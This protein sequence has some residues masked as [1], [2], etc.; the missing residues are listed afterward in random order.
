MRSKRRKSILTANSRLRFLSFLAV[1]LWCGL[2]LAAPKFP[3][4]TGRVVDDAH[5]LSSDSVAHLDQILEDYERGTGNQVVVITLPSL[6]NYDIADYGYQLGR[7]WGIG[8]KD[9][10]TGALLIVAPNERKVRIE[11]GYGLEGTLT[12][13]QS[14]I[15]IQNVILPYF[16]QGA[17]E[18]G[19]IAGTQAILDVLG[20]KSVAAPDNQISQD[21]PPI[22][23][24]VITLLLFLIFGGRSFFWGSLLGA[25]MGGFGRSSGGFG[26]GGGGFSGGGGSFGGGGASGSW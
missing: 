2:A 14:E 3:A 6:Q 10:N 12:D 9:K 20:G 25:S 1:L 11:V 17:M 5:I 26:G 23:L 22:W 24:I 16:K 19:V 15:I 13:A 21:R 4:L 7:A 8:Q 18:Q